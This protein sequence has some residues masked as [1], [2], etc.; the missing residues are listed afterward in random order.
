MGDALPATAAR[1][2]RSG[3]YILGSEVAAFEEAFARYLGARHAVGVAN[4]TDA[5][6]IALRACGVLAGD[7]VLMCANAGMYAAVAAQAIG[8]VPVFADI[9]ASGL[10][11]TETLEEAIG[12]AGAPPRAVVV[13]HLYGRVGDIDAILAWARRHRLRVVEDCAQAHGARIGSRM[14]GAFGDAA[15]FSFYPTKNLGALGDGGMVVSG[16]A[17]IDARARALREYGWTRRYH[18]QVAGGRNSRLDEL[19]AACSSCR[20]WTRATRAAVRS[21]CATRGKSGIH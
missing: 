13:T 18:A 9:D 15:A 11:N 4:G 10:L 19:Q 6:E 8:A 14:A 5:L 3:R 16:E 2:I 12:H 17:E 20:V 7:G 1:V 21:P